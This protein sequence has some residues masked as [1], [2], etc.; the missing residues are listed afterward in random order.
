MYFLEDSNQTS[1]SNFGFFA[2]DRDNRL[3]EMAKW[4]DKAHKG[5]KRLGLMQRNLVVVQMAAKYGSDFA[6]KF[7]DQL[8]KRKPQDMV[9]HYYG[10]GVGP[11]PATLIQRGYKLAQKDSIHEWWVH[12]SGEEVVRNYSDDVTA[13]P[14]PQA[15]R[16][17]KCRE[18]DT[19]AESICYN[20]DK[21]CEIAAQLN[22]A[23]SRA[24][25]EEARSS[26]ADARRTATACV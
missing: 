1:H 20:A 22:D 6:K 7:L 17:A 11:K 24:K 10:R 4:P 3:K 18:M 2:D 5:F 9:S 13:A 25:C 21:I 16:A 14:K 15:A 23:A 26:C 12:P 19:I 8:G